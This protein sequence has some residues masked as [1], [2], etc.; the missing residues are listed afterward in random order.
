MYI[1]IS[2]KKTLYIVSMQKYSDKFLNQSH[3][4]KNSIIGMEFEFYMKDLSYYKTLEILNQELAPVKVWGFRQYHSDFEPDA[5]NFKIEPDLSGGSNMVELVTGPLDYYDAKYYLVKIIKFIQNYGYT[6]EKASIHFNVSFKSDTKDLNDL[7]ILKLI[8]NT[9]EDEIYRFY[10]SRKDNIYAK[11]VKKIIPYKEFDFFNIAIETIKNNIRLP[12]DKY[13]GINFSHVNKNK[14]SQRLEYRYIGGKDY[15]KNIGQLIY[16][17]ERFIINVH[18]CIDVGFDQDDEN[19]LEEYLERNISLFKTFSKYD[20]FLVE[21]PGIQIQ[22]DQNNNYDLVSAYFPRIYNKIFHLLD[23]TNQLKECILNYVSTTQTIEIVDANIKATST[24]KGFDFISSKIEGIF[25]DCFFVGCEIK[26]SQLTKSKLQQSEALNSKVLKCNIDQSTLTGCYFME[27]Y[28]N[29]DMHGGVF[30][31]GELG[32]YAT[33][34]SDVKVVTDYNNFFD[35]R[36]DLEDD[37]PTDKGIMKVYGKS[38][39]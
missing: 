13:F 21:F 15:E 4:L 25:E 10:P 17:M 29:G 32:P 38:K 1:L 8:L 5:N 27:G 14:E 16:F 33:M 24:L 11:S 34:D 6:N 7:N 9:D 31:S 3:K 20:N 22:I 35:T 19:K 39:E 36:F 28:L 2:K 37:K 12:S 26:N 30:R 23:N 18:D